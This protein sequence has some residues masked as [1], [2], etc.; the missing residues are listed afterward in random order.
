M[1]SAR[2]LPP[3]ALI[4]MPP[5]WVADEGHRAVD[6]AMA[7][8][9]SVTWASMVTSLRGVAS[10]RRVPEGPGDDA[11]A[12]GLEQWGESVPAPGAVPKRRGRATWSWRGIPFCQARRQRRAVGIL[13]LDSCGGQRFADLVG[14]GETDAARALYPFVGQRVDLSVGRAAYGTRPE[15]G[16]RIPR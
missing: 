13:E 5:M 9:I 4:T 1:R 11:H 10:Q 2:S 3:P 14:A 7:M 16:F 8:S 6:I 15:P 12:G